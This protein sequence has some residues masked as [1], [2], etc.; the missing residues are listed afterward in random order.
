MDKLNKPTF[1]KHKFTVPREAYYRIGYPDGTVKIELLKIGGTYE[2]SDA[3]SLTEIAQTSPPNND[4][5]EA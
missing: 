4:K 2:L 5:G 3:N 1:G